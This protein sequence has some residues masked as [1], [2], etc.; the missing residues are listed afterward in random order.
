MHMEFVCE[1]YAM[2]V[3]GNRYFLHE[4]PYGA[5]SWSLSC[6][7]RTMALQGVE[8][9]RADQCQFGQ[10][11]KNGRPI[12]KP[13]G[14]M[15]NSPLLLKELRRVCK[16]EKGY[17]RGVPETE[18]LEHQHCTGAV[19]RGAAI[20]PM[21]L[22]RDILRGISKQLR[23]DGFF[24]DD[25]VGMIEPSL[26]EIIHNVQRNDAYVLV[27]DDGKAPSGMFRDDISGQVLHDSIVAEAQKKEM[28]YFDLKQV[29]ELRSKEEC[30]KV[31]GKKPITVRWVLTNKGDDEQPN[32]RARLVARQIRHAGIES[33]FAPTPPLE[34]VRT[35][36]SLAATRLP[37]D[38]EMCRDPASEERIQLSFLD[39]SRAYFNARTDPKHPTYVDLPAEHPQHGRMV[40]LLKRHMYGT[41]RAADGWQEEYSCALVNMGFVQGV[42]SPCVFHHPKWRLVTAVH[43]DDFTT[44]GSK[45]NLDMF[46]KLLRERYELKSGGRLGPGNG[47]DKQAMVLNRVVQWTEDGVTVEADP[48]QA[49][50][51]LYELGIDDNSKTLSTPGLKPTK[52]QVEDDKPLGQD[53]HT[54]YRGSSARCNYLSSDRPDMQ[55]SAKEVCRFMA[56]PTE[57]GLTALKRIGRYLN[58]RRRLVYHYPFQSA[59]TIQVYSD[60]DWAG[61][62]KTRKSTSGGCVLLGGHCLKSWSS[63]QPTVSLSSGE[64]EFYGLVKAAGVGLGFKSMLQDFGYDLGVTA[65]TDSSAAMGVVGRQ[66]LGRLRHL[67]T[68]SLWIQHAVRSKRIVVKKVR[69]EDNVADLFTKHLPSRDRINYLTGLLGCSFLDGRAECAPQMRRDRMDRLTLGEATEKFDM[70]KP[71]KVTKDFGV[72]DEE[73]QAFVDGFE[74]APSVPSG[75]LPHQC[76]GGG[77]AFPML[78]VNEVDYKEDYSDFC[79]GYVNDGFFEKIG[80]RIAKEIV[81]EARTNGRRRNPV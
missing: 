63:T 62:T 24:A 20:Y 44:R 77:A 9:I 5:S 6:I 64:A 54:L 19:A 4:H 31:T 36:L 67:D 68:H 72:E 41:L 12:M 56:A 17:C 33:I 10:R 13:T 15:S 39:I 58:D 7:K 37:G 79:D 18:G 57:L 78:Q 29:W 75:F 14:F 22:C 30:M 49:E 43:G 66:G 38:S 35:V 45:R 21:K 55:F 46:E 48:R 51:V 70:D 2:Q 42:S 74:E 52:A 8:E 60:T 25:E 34:A 1:L 50:K 27:S 81:I 80:D 65:W 53:K 76:P 40:G 26:R 11:A 59:D 69:G 28:D 73:L 47:D 71:C 23:A 16:G 3:E 32:Y 61:C